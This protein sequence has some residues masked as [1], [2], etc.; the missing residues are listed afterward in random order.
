MFARAV[1]VRFQPDKVDD[2][3]RIV[4]GEIVPAMESEEG[5]KGQLLLTQPDTGKAISINFWE[6]EEALSA[7]GSSPRYGELMGKLAGV[8]AG[9]PEGDRYQV[10]IRT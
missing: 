2:A 1:N 4:E 7:F 9:P 3:C 6:T 8:L 10:A 5:L